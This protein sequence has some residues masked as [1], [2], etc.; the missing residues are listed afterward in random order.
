M[1]VNTKDLV[2]KPVNE[3]EKKIVIDAFTDKIKLTEEQ[4]KNLF[5]MQSRKKA[6]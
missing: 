1:T 3:E 4:K 2:V 6:C 5:T